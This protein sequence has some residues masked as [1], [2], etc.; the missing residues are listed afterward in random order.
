MASGSRTALASLRVGAAHPALQRFLYPALIGLGFGIL[1]D[2]R[3]QVSPSIPLF[4]ERT[5]LPAF[6]APFPGSVL[7]YAGG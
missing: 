3:E 5:G 4:L 2:A 1:L 7:F 6:N